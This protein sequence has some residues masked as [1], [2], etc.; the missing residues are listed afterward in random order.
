LP[1]LRREEAELL[2]PQGDLLV[3][4]R[5]QHGNA[6]DPHEGFRATRADDVWRANVD[7]HPASGAQTIV[8]QAHASTR[9]HAESAW[10][11]K[12]SAITNSVITIKVGRP[13]AKS[14]IELPGPSHGL[15]A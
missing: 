13:A 6:P 12:N 3:G 1:R 11:V 14:V 2:P 15:Q 7:G 8:E 9:I 4:P 5:E 10:N